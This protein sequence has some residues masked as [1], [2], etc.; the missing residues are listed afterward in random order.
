MFSRRWTALSRSTR[1]SPGSRLRQRTARQP[2]HRSWA[3]GVWCLLFNI[4]PFADYR[5]VPQYADIFRAS[6]QLLVPVE[7]GRVVFQ[8]RRIVDGIVGQA[9]P[10]PLLVMHAS[11]AAAVEPGIVT[12]HRWHPDEVED[13]VTMLPWRGG[14]VDRLKMLDVQVSFYAGVARKVGHADSSESTSASE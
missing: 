3:A 7:L 10:D 5:R 8:D 11:P 9:E 6:S 14:G 13:A 1:V 2:G 12:P 4:I